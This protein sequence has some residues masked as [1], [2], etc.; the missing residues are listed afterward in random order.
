MSFIIGGLVT[1]GYI[2]AGCLVAKGFDFIVRKFNSDEEGLYY[3][4]EGKELRRDYTE[5]AVIG[6]WPLF[7]G[8]GLLVIFIHILKGITGVLVI[9][10][11]RKVSRAESFAGKLIADLRKDGFNEEQIVSILH[12]IHESIGETK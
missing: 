6:F 5:F 11:P 7:L 8:I 2:L 1:I 3:T 10:K 12:E 9:G 4:R